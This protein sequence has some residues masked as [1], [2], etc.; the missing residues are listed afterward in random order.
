MSLNSANTAVL[1]FKHSM[2]QVRS[3]D[4]QQGVCHRLVHVLVLQEVLVLLKV[5]KCSVS[6]E[7]SAGNQAGRTAVQ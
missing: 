1:G 5:V 3:N 6:S 7:M 2:G 4:R